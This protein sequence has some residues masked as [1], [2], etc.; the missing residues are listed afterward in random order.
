V[1]L[2]EQWAAAWSRHDVDGLV[3]LFTDDCEYEDVAFEIVNQEHK[4]VCDWATGFLESFPDLRVEPIRSFEHDRRAVLEWKMGGTHLGDFDGLAPTRRHWSVRGVTVLDIED[5]RIKRCAG[6][7]RRFST[8][9]PP[10][11]GLEQP[12]HPVLVLAHWSTRSVGVRAPACASGRPL[13]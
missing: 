2:G 5:G 8:I 11:I 4:G 13:V 1:S 7:T 12:R 6:A 3:H 9:A 10:F